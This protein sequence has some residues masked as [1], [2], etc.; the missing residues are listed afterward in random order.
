MLIGSICFIIFL[1]T[2]YQLSKDDF[3]F[4]RKG[5]TVEDVFNTVF[6]SLPI[7]FLFSRLGYVLQHPS[8]HY[9]NPLV[10]LLVP[11]FPGL[12]FF[13]SVVGIGLFS[14]FYIE[15]KKLPAKRFLDIV[16]ISFL[17]SFSIWILLLG[18]EVLMKNKIM[19]VEE[20]G[21]SML[22]VAL[23]IFVLFAFLRSRWNE[24]SVAYMSGISY[25]ILAFIATGVSFLHKTKISFVPLGLTAF[26]FLVFL[27]LF[28]RSQKFFLK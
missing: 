7:V 28:F 11:Y 6:L 20:I 16:G 12:S 21:R 24:G 15:R 10:F 4:L 17:L 19:G 18:I 27:L 26:L 22:G 13:G 5:V 14:T 8:L 1:F 2:V 25:C 23:F 9:F 3:I